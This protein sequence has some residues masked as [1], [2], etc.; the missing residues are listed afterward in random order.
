TTTPTRTR[1][2]QDTAMPNLVSRVIRG[3]LFSW[4]P[5]RSAHSLVGWVESSRPTTT[6]LGPWWVSKTR[7]TLHDATAAPGACLSLLALLC[8]FHSSTIAERAAA[9]FCCV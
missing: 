1:K 4:V 9:L 6:L 8:F 5:F 3:L 2:E 7:P